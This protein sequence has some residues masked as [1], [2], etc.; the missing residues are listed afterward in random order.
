MPDRLGACEDQER[1][2]QVKML[3]MV[4]LGKLPGAARLKRLYSTGSFHEKTMT[5]TFQKRFAAFLLTGAAMA[6][7][8]LAQENP[9]L[10]Q[11][12]ANAKVAQALVF[13]NRW[14][15]PT[16][17]PA[18][19]TNGLV[20]MVGW[21]TT[22]LAGESALAAHLKTVTAQVGWKFLNFSCYGLAKQRP[23]AFSRAL[24]LK[25]SAIIVADIDARDLAKEM[26][27]ATAKKIPVIGWH[28]GPTPGATEGLFT[29]VATNP[30]DVGQVAAL[31]SVVNSKG[32]AGVVVLTDSTAA[33]SAIKANAM[34]DTIK[35]CQTCTLLGIEEM[36]FSSTPEHVKEVLTALVGKYGS[37]WTYVLG[38]D[39]LYFD[40]LSKPAAKT[41]IDTY[42]LEGI[43][44][45]DG[46]PGAYQRIKEGHV[47][48]GTV[49][50]P[51]QLD[52]WQLV[53]EV[54]RAVS[55][56]PPSGYTTPVYLVTK[57]NISFNGGPTGTFE[58]SNGYQAAY[59]GIWKK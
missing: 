58:P 57:Q 3:L 31:L 21:D 24:A 18:I 28:A 34:A 33:Y 47:Q 37:R 14:D 38:T 36:P 45:G 39:D 59:K 54:N 53:D 48:S 32:K 56:S 11:A 20:I 49:P 15:G 55:G 5:S 16:T 52:A 42:K 4:R 19:K 50:E 22:H 41:I 51:L 2:Q 25:P 17:G 13:P 26:R 23:E 35:Q 40:M 8:A 9:A 12:R 10:F 6:S 7:S 30:Q 44:A 43:S 29:N 46:A 27:M 1:H